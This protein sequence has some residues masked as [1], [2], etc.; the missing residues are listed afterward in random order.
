MIDKAL[1]PLT[2][3]P[4]D[5]VSVA[6]YERYAKHH[7]PPAIFEY[8]QGGGADEITLQ[9]NR[10]ALDDLMIL[11]RVLQD[12]T[13]GGT[14]TTLLGEALRHPILL[15]P[16]AFQKLVH[17]Q[18]E[19]AMAQAASVLETGMIVST[20][21]SESIEA[22]AAELDS[23]K[24]F[25]L[26]FQHS[27]DF[28]LALVKRAQAAGY[29]ALVITV[30]APLHGIR[31]RAQR[32]GFQ[33]PKGVEAVNLKNRPPLPSQQFDASESIV[34][35]GMMSEAPVWQDIHWLKQHTTL[36]IVLK[37]VLNPADALYAAEMGLAGVVVSNHGGRTLDCLPSAVEMLP[38]V[39]KAVGKD[40]PLFM[41]GGI[42]RGTDVFK[43]LALG[44]DA[45]LIGRPQLYALAVAGALG[46]AHML[47]VLREELE[48]T[49]SL[50]GTPTIKDITRNALLKNN[51]S[52]F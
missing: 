44:A 49:M 23:P 1:P 43:A 26:Y 3:V 48:V 25:Q 46:V 13:A 28:T 45:V 12:C 9:R 40:F 17:P 6:D 52:G 34:F 7:I 4:A 16:V 39:R 31:N 8:I 24:W 20:L 37:G 22:I 15:A 50:A 29:T 35:Q 21:A 14:H 2:A 33:L 42:Q 5:L 32:A 19:L 36:P 30:D 41:D 38:L 11:P 10:R 18:G 27:R 47:R 51:I